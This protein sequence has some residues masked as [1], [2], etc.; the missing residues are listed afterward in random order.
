MPARKDLKR[1]VRARM[2]KTGERYT[3]ARAQLLRKRPPPRR[4]TP[5]GPLAGDL[6]ALAGMSDASVAKRTGRTWKEWVG[7]LDSAGAA[8]LTH[9]EIARMV[10][11]R[12]GLPDWWAQT[13]TV[14]YERI[15]GL[16]EKGQRRDG[17]FEVSKSKV[18]PVP[19]EELWKGFLRCKVWLGGETLRMSKATKHKTMRMRWKDGTPVDAGF[20]SK[21]PGKSQ[22]SLGHRKLAS[23]AEAERLRTF[24]GERLVALGKLLAGEG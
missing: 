21:G 4:A 23:R 3:T 12:H 2:K 11:N 6:A 22:V 15:R 18:Y 24:W 17:T 16:R 7:V 5:P 1:L 10:G 19:L 20:Y 8:K 14:G 13:V 9:T